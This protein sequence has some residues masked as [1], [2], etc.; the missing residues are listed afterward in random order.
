MIN[1]QLAVMFP[2]QGS[3]AVGMLSDIA[4]QYPCRFAGNVSYPRCRGKRGL[5]ADR[6]RRERLHAAVPF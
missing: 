6:D 2:G 3:Q 4:N 1:A 5:Q